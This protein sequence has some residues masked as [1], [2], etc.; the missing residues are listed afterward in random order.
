MIEVAD[1]LAGLLEL[2]TALNR[3]PGVSRTN[4][5]HWHIAREEIARGIARRVGKIRKA[6]GIA[7]PTAPL[8]FCARQVD[9][10]RQFVQNSGRRIPIERRASRAVQP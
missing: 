1:E 3:L 10:G 6:L 5:E 7:E 9:E 4:P 2:A 8:S